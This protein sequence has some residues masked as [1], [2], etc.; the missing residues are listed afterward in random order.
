[1]PQFWKVDATQ[2]INPEQIVYVEDHPAW[3]QPT[4]DVTMTVLQSSIQE[5]GI[6]RRQPNVRNWAT[7]ICKR[8]NQC[9]M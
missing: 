1:M 9:L 3:E 2:W 4:I 8:Q 7:C 5:S 6:G